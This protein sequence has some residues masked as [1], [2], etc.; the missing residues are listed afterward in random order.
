MINNE[1]RYFVIIEYHDGDLLFSSYYYEA[2]AL[3]LADHFDPDLH[4]KITILEKDD[5]SNLY[6][7]K[8]VRQ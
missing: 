8:E 7:V 1:P 4:S 3:E 5:H 2:T 6:H